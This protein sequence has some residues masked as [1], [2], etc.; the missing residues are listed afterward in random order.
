[1]PSNEAVEKVLEIANG[2]DLRASDRLL[3]ETLQ[4]RDLKL[5]NYAS[6]GSLNRAKTRWLAGQKNSRPLS[7]G[8]CASIWVTRLEIHQ[9]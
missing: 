8:L 3:R 6:T 2:S 5:P 9:F 7:L 4:V 1:M